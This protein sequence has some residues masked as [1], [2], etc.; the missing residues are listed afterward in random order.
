L[1]GSE[2]VPGSALADS[3]WPCRVL[4]IGDLV[5]PRGSWVLVVDLVEREVD[6]EAVG[7]GAMPV[8]LVGLEEHAVAGTQDFDGPP[9]RWQRPMPS[10]T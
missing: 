8:V 6:H 7:R 1:A 10:V 9:R 2:A 4:L 5:A 3:D